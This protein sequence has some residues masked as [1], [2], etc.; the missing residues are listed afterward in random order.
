[1]RK[2]ILKFLYLILFIAY[3]TVV[4]LFRDRQEIILIGVISLPIVM[5]II[6]VLLLKSKR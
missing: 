4:F 1:M 5:A 6:G 3:V 2:N